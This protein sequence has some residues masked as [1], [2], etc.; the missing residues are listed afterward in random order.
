MQLI[1]CLPGQLRLKGM[2]QTTRFPLVTQVLACWNWKCAFMS[3]SVR[4][5]VYLA[6]MARGGVHGRLAVVAVEIVYVILTAG[7]W[8]GL[9]QRALGLRT[10]LAGNLVVALLVPALAQFCDWLTHRL[11]GAVAPSH[12]TFAVCVFTLLSA[13][14]HLYVMRRGAF[15][16]GQGRSLTEDFRRMPHLVAG[17]VLRPAGL[18]SAPASRLARTFE[19]GAA[20]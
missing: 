2:V 7:L 20:Y 5:L 3:A 18:F 16:T 11:T 15:L 10:R 19:S 17:F 4:S 12:A 14:F 8:A 1:L 6:A 13:L 9:Q